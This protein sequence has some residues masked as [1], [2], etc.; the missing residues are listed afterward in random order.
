MKSKFSNIAS[1]HCNILD[2][3]PHENITYTISGS[4]GGH[5]RS[6]LVDSPTI[7]RSEPKQEFQ[8]E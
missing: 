6:K 7:Y 4:S 5:F 2:I 3:S 1:S 8:S